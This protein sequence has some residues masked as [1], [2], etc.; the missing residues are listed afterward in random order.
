MLLVGLGNPGG[1]YEANRHNIGFLAID[2]IADRFGFSSFRKKF[3]GDLSEGTLPGCGK[4]LLLKPTT[5]M[6]D[7]GQSVG[8]A[9]RFYKI[10]VGD[11]IVFHDELD[12]A[13]GKVKAKTG[14][15]VAGHNGLRS[16]TAHLGNDYRR[17]R[18]GIGHP[19][20]K[21]KVHG[22]VLGDFSKAD[23]DWLDTLIDALAASAPS[24]IDGDAS[25]TSELGRQLKPNRKTVKQSATKQSMAPTSKNHPKTNLN[26]DGSDAHFA[27]KMKTSNKRSSPFIDVLKGLTPKK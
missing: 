20:D 18:I 19:G 13:P 10:D 12:L 16:I 15:G 2:A 24:L 22:Y 23:R 17:V 6:N 7:S 9:T 4:V 14:G 3:Q 11:V 27:K 25:F 5:F 1:K 8:E 21:A 26:T